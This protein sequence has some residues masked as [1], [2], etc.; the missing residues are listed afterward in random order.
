MILSDIDFF[1]QEDY[2]HCIIKRK[3]VFTLFR[4]V[5]TW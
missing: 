5:N 3:H 1:I 2:A 4:E